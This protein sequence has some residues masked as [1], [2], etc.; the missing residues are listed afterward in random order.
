MKNKKGFTLIELLLALGLLGIVSTVIFSIFISNINNFE[1][2][3][4]R[5]EV[6]QNMRTAVEFIS[7]EAM[8]SKG[9]EVINKKIKQD[10][11]KNHKDKEIEM[12]NIILSTLLETNNGYEYNRKIFAFKRNILMYGHI[13]K[14]MQNITGTSANMEV[15]FYIKKINLRLI[16]QEE[17][18]IGITFTVHTDEKYNI[19]PITTSVY[20]RNMGVER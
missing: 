9:I 7:R 10:D 15:A 17:D 2:N 19:K 12:N 5:I 18:V 3:Q 8:E 16:F 14:N 1:R 13:S 4:K 6:Q 20:F 11:F